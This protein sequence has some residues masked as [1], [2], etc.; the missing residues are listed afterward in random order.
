MTCVITEFHYA[1]LSQETPYLATVE[2]F[3]RNEIQEML[4][5]HLQAYYQFHLERQGDLD[6]EELGER[7]L[8]ART[9]LDVLVAIFAERET[10]RN[11]DCAREFLSNA[12]SKDDQHILQCF[13]TWIDEFMGKYKP[14]EGLICLTAS[15]A[16]ELSNRLEPW[17]T[18]NSMVEE[19]GSS[20]AP[21]FWPI[22]RIV[23][24]G[25]QSLLLQRGVILSD[26]PG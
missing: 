4:Q 12:T 13:S 14:Q 2:L 7:E 20:Q 19:D 18:S 8:Q 26:L 25:M 6:E 15:T 3:G 11:E 5:E 9:A 16:E 22:V 23:R 24:V 21:S 10:F 1:P 17:V